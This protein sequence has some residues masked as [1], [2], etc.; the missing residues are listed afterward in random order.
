[1]TTST[2]FDLANQYLRNCTNL[3]NNNATEADIVSQSRTLHRQVFNTS[4]SSARAYTVLSNLSFNMAIHESAVNKQAEA[5]VTA[6]VYGLRKEV[7]FERWFFDFNFHHPIN[8]NLDLMNA[9]CCAVLAA[10]EGLVKAMAALASSVF[11][12]VFEPGEFD[13]QC[14]IL[15]AQMEGVSY[16]LAAIVSPNYVKQEAGRELDIGNIALAHDSWRTNHS[17]GTLYT[18]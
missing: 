5:T 3:V 8:S 6:L 13:T 15:D 17:W 10:C 16:S 12:L 9:R 7:P 18:G 4:G 1:M 14:D 2:K 11:A